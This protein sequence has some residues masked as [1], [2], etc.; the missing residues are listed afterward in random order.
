MNSILFIHSFIHSFIQYDDGP[1]TPQLQPQP[2]QD[3]ENN[4]NNNNESNTDGDENNLVVLDPDHPLLQRF[5]VALNK[6]LTRIDEK[7]TLETRESRYD[8]ERAKRE[9]E[10]LGVELYGLQQELAKHQMLVEKEH[11]SFNEM[12]QERKVIENE[13]DSIRNRYRKNQNHV[14]DELRKV[15]DL[16]LERDNLKLRIFYMSNAKEDIRGDIA[17]IRRATEKADIDKN[18]FEVDKQRQVNTNK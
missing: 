13:L 10:E 8:L 18:K 2:I 3:S 9:R 6:Q 12:S 16:Q 4:N 17:V 14:N 7:L 11:D 15:R 5:Q 1:L